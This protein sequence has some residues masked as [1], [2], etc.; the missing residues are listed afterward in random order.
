MSAAAPVNE[1]APYELTPRQRLAQIVRV[2][3]VVQILSLEA[4]GLYYVLFE[5]G[6]SMA[7]L[8]TITTWIHPVH[9]WLLGVHPLTNTGLWHHLVPDGFDRDALRKA[10]E[11]VVTG[12]GGIALGINALSRRRLR[13]TAKHPNWF[14][15]MEMR[16]RIPNA[17]DKS[18][19]RT[20]ELPAL[21]G[22]QVVGAW[23]FWR[24]VYALVVIVPL[25]YLFSTLAHGVANYASA[26]VGP[27]WAQSLQ[28]PFTGPL[29]Y[30]LVGLAASPVAKRPVGPVIAEI[31][32]WRA[33]SW[34]ASGDRQFRWYHRV[35]L[36]PQ[37]LELVR[38]AWAE[39]RGAARAKL[40]NRSGWVVAMMV[41]GRLLFLTF[42]AI[43]V[44]VRFS[45]A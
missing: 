32:A 12:V 21:S 37:Y 22:W 39:G 23:L 33:E 27:M 5:T 38:R 19:R 25:L 26:A 41:V 3:I 1:V 13:K 7:W 15:S 4:W 24:W 45:I 10:L 34:A 17:K 9:Q 2:L 14:D 36:S 42:L 28:E 30:F 44:W 11:A 35:L 8:L 29:V 18:Y 31:Q 40:K 43:G 20:K 6:V 16:V